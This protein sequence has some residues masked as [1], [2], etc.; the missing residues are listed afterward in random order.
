MG[1]K[2]FVNF[3]LGKIRRNRIGSILIVLGIVV[4]SIASFTNAIDAI[5]NF[6]DKFKRV[7]DPTSSELI[8]QMAKYIV[9]GSVKRG[10]YS[11]QI[12]ITPIGLF[13]NPKPYEAYNAETQSRKIYLLCRF[14]N[15]S[16]RP[17][18]LGGVEQKSGMRVELADLGLGY[19][20]VMISLSQTQSWIGGNYK[21]KEQLEEMKD[22]PIKYEDLI[23]LATLKAG[24]TK[25]A[26]LDNLGSTWP[27]VLQLE[28]TDAT[29]SKVGECEIMIEIKK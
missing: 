15:I 24:E 20:P 14:T 9:K 5:S 21:T 17:I 22:R 27:Q 6:I 4:I 18:T 28:V 29:D 25:Y 10:Q 11:G 16:D 8:E 12:V 26:Y 2:D 19:Q 3:F 1:K 7:N 13:S 23:D